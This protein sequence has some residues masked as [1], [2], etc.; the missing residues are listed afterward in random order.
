MSE[1][2]KQ[3]FWNR[4]V[5]ECENKIEEKFK[6]YKNSWEYTSDSEFWKKRLQDE[7]NE[8]K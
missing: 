4:I 5:E 8:L 6:E 7:V 3:P 2:I 1:T